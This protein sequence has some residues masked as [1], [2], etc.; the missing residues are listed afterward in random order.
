MDGASSGRQLSSESK[1]NLDRADRKIITMLYQPLMGAECLAL[2]QTL[3]TEV[4][5]KQTVV[6][7]AFARP[8]FKYA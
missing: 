2:Y 5:E 4:E 1:W 3:F 8:T 7:S 6:R